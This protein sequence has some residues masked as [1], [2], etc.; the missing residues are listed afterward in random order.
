[1]LMMPSNAC[2]RRI[3]TFAV[4]LAGRTALHFAAGYG[5][6]EAV[7][8]LLTANAP[9]AAVDVHGDA[10]LHLVRLCIIPLPHALALAACS[11]GV[12][13]VPLMGRQCLYRPQ[14]TAT[15]WRHSAWQR[16]RRMLCCLPTLVD[17][18]LWMLQR[19]ASITRWVTEYEHISN[20]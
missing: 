3:L 20:H 12:Q 14:R 19:C 1:M 16:Q 5:N 6:E 4:V 8:M 18:R 2:A 11:H 7:E 10:P 15:P 17:R 9:P 13:L